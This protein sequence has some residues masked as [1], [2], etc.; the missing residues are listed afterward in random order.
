MYEARISLS[1][2]RNAH[3][4]CWLFCEVLQAALER[5]EVGIGALFAEFKKR[6]RVNFLEILL[7]G[8]AEFV[9]RHV[10]GGVLFCAQCLSQ[11]DC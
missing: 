3:T 11:S 10:S 7:S 6:V 5:F 8:L 2:A 4:Y 1:Y 9:L